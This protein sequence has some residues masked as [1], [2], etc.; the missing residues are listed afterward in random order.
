MKIVNIQHFCLDDGPGIRTTVF[1]AG[2]NMQC[3]WCH[4]PEAVVENVLTY[5]AKDISIQKLMF[6]INEDKLFY[7]SSGGG[8]TFS[9]GEP[10]LQITELLE[11]LQECKREKISVVIE[12]A[13]NYP[14]ELLENILD[15]VD[16]FIIDCKAFSNEL[17]KKCTGKSN[18][19]ILKNIKMLSE[20][21]RRL[22]IRIPIVWG[23]NILDK[24]M[25][26]I[27]KFLSTMEFERVEL[28]PYHKMGISKYKKYGLEYPL[29]NIEPPTKD[30]MVECSNILK[31]YNIEA[32]FNMES[33]E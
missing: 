13:G 18:I 32:C 7:E 16:L 6:H 4:N 27:G 14:F 25:D 3:L 9:G 22:W 30:Q 12:T 20:R 1:L 26:Q 31:R 19:S 29:K 15:C 17:H 21:K 23:V 11:V 10:V 8:V 2:C 33:S 28:I 24:E 5:T